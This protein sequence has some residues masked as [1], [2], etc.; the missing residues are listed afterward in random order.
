MYTGIELQRKRILPISLKLIG[1]L[2][3]A[4]LFWT[5][6]R[7]GQHDLFTLMNW[8][9][10]YAAEEAFAL[11]KRLRPSEFTEEH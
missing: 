1:Q 9:F 7:F 10:L 2:N 8:M 6:A 11:R 3:N 4:G 5:F